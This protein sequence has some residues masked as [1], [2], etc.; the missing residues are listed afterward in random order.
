MK[1]SPNDLNPSSV[2]YSNL[3]I[4]ME[5]GRHGNNGVNIVIVITNSHNKI[6]LSMP[7]MSVNSM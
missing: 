5:G 2:H 7:H 3:C 6:L 4:S 1:Y